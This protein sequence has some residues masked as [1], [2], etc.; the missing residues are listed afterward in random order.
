MTASN[1]DDNNQTREKLDSLTFPQPPQ[2]EVLVESFFP[3][4]QKKQER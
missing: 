2:K 1:R 3:S 4:K